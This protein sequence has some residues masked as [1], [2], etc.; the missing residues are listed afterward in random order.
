MQA[1]F[2]DLRYSLRQL[3]KNPG[4]ALTAVFSLALGIGASTAV[5]SV[6]YAALM[7]PYPYPAASRIVRLNVKSSTGEQRQVNLDGPEIRLLRQSPV[8]EGAIAMDSWSLPLTGGDFPEDVEAIFITSNGFDFLG[9][10]PLLGRGILPSDAIDGQEPQPVIVLSYKFWQRHF[11]GSPDAVGKTLQLN[12]KSYRIVGVAAQRATWYSADVYLPLKLTQDPNL[13]YI[14]NFRVK[15]GISRQS[16]SAALQPLIEQFAHQ[17]P[18]RF[19]AHFQ[20]ALHGLNDWVVKSIGHILYLL[21]AGVALLLLI[22]CGNVSILL[23]ARGTLRQHELAVRAAIGAGRGRIIRQLLTES[24]LLSIT[25]AA[26]GVLLAYGIVAAI[27]LILPQ[28]AFAPEVAIGINLPVLF[29]SIGVALFTGILFGLWP[30]LRL[31]RPGLSSIIQ[32]GTRS[33]AGTAHSHKAHHLLISAQIALTLLLLAGAGAAIESFVRL[34]H[35]PLGYDPHN[36]IS[37]WIPLQQNAYTTSAARSAYFEQLRDRVANVPGVTMTAIS[38]NATPP[39]GGDSMHF[40]LLGKP[41]IEDQSALVNLVDPGFF[42][43]LRIPLRQGRFWNETE[44]RDG[45]HLAV[46]NQSLARLYFPKGDSVGHSIK[47]PSIESR[48]PVVLSAPQIADAWLQ[49]VGIAGDSRNDGLRNPVKPAIFIPYTLDMP[50]GTQLL[51]KSQV[52]PLTLLPDIRRAISSA[53]PD[54]QTA[55]VVSDLDHWISDQPEWQQEHLIAWIFA[56]YSILALALAAVGLYS[57]V[58]YSVVQ[59]TNEFGIR[60]ALGA[61]RSHVLRIVFASTLISVGSGVL[62]GL[63]LAL[64]LNTFLLRWVGGNLHDPITLLAGALVLT[65]VSAIASFIPAQRATRIDPMKALRCE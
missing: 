43:T 8:V 3:T 42:S 40:E 36:V 58:S 55:R 60:M 53:N 26:L 9:V 28:Y 49:I 16:A 4:F 39:E 45:R 62:A 44:N 27:K 47:L 52:P 21:L 13:T 56:A 10:P 46:I 61:Q 65:L 34:M 63:L 57:V 30:A 23:L 7:N 15:P 24:L 20:V 2:Q 50:P 18:K 48:P 29:F 17:T 1:V 11:N 14:V 38:T 33:V 64:A 41:A 59:R 37:I 32:S 54:Q 25:G 51:V 31:S 5:F 22:G 6:I 12:R 19:P 35:A